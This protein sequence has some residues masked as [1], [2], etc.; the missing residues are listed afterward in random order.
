[1]CHPN[2]IFVLS[3]CLFSVLQLYTVFIFLSSYYH[4]YVIVFPSE[5]IEVELYM[6][7]IYAGMM[8]ACE[9]HPVSGM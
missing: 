9:T 8:H 4:L 3:V 1:M 6:F 2:S 7:C 5:I